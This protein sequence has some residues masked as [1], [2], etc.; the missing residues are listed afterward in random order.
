VLLKGHFPIT[1]AHFLLGCG[2]RERTK[3]ADPAEAFFIPTAFLS[4]P[5]L[6]GLAGPVI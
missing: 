1:K 4:T 2:Q 6:P 3:E 5:Y